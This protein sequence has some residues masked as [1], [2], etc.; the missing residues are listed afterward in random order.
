MDVKPKT[1]PKPEE[2]IED[3][4]PNP[5]KERRAYK[6]AKNLERELGTIKVNID[7]VKD[8]TETEFV[9]EEE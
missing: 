8:L 6:K 1:L 2:P 5:P 4:I 7:M 3:T 9:F